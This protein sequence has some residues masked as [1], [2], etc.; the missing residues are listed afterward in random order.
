MNLQLKKKNY[1]QTKFQDWTASHR[2][3]AKYLK[4]NEYLS[5]SN[6]SK[7]LKRTE[8][9]QIHSTKPTLPWYQNQTKTPQK[10]KLQANSFDEYTCKNPQQN[11]SKTNPTIYKKIIHPDQ[12]GFIPGTQ[13]WFNIHKLMWYTIL[14]KGMINSLDH[15]N[16][17]RKS[18]WQNST[19]IH[20]KNLSSKWV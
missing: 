20:D 7:K 18:M 3:S 1:Q 14:T 6:Y 2:N 11:I 8:H 17:C 9:C 5:F 13:G 4:K 15:L 12:V 16:R 19:S 10:R